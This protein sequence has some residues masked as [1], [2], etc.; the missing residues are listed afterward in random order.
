MTVNEVCGSG[1]KAV[2]L[3]KQL[4]QLGEAEVLIAGGLRICPKHLN[5]NDLITKQKA[6]MRLF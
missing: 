4:I 2:I 1:M 5:Y 6:M 3:A